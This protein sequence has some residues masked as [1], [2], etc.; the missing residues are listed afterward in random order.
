MDE[1]VDEGYIRSTLSPFLLTD[2]FIDC[3]HRINQKIVAV[4][5]AQLCR[6]S[7]FKRN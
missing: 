2:Q 4:H 5:N 3:I 1:R 7:T 6:Y